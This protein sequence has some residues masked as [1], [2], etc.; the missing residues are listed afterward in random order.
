MN[1]ILTAITSFPGILP[2]VILAVLIVFGLLAIAGFLDIHHVGPNWGFDSNHGINL[3]HD[4]HSDAA[5]EMLVAL[6]FRRMPFFVVISSIGFAWWVLT[7]VAQL[8]LMPLIPFSSWMT[9]LMVLIAAFIFALPLAAMV[10]RPLK[11]IFADR[12]EGART[13]D[14]VGRACKIVTGSVDWKFGQAEVIVDA[15]AHH[16]LQVYARE[17]NALKRGSSA[18]ILQYDEKTKRFEVEAYEV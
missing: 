18:L 9:G 7:M 14:F 16:I 17:P 15:G 8:Y 3:N 1:E 2:S 5:P 11:P 6:G 13:P 4:G 10:V 12:S